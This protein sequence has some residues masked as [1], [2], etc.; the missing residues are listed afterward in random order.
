ME[1]IEIDL[2]G[3]SKKIN[4]KFIPLIKD[5][6]PLQIV[7]GG[8]NSS[9]SYSYAEKIIYHTIREKYFRCLATRKV[10]KDVKHSVYDQL[11][12]VL[13]RYKLENY[14]TYNNTESNLICKLNGNDIL[15]VGLDDVNKLKSFT[16][17]TF[18][19]AEEADQMTPND[20]EQLS[21]RLRGPE[22]C[23]FQGG[24]TLN[25]ISA[26]HWI[27][28][29]Y[30]NNE[31]VNWLTHRSTY[32]D[33]KFLPKKIIERME[34]ITDPYYKRVYVDGEWGI[35][36]NVVFTNY[37]IEDFDYTE[38]D[39]YNVSNGIDFGFAHASAFERCGFIDDEIYFF[40]EVWGKGWTNSDFIK[41]IVEAFGIECTGWPITAESA[42]PD[43]VEEFRRYGFT[44]F[45][46]AKKGPGSLKYGIDYL[47]SKKIHIHSSKCM[48]LAKEIQ[49]F[50]RRE[51]KDGNTID[52]FVEIN[53]DC[54]AAAR[55]AT[56]YIW[57]NIENI[58]MPTEY[59]LEDL[60]L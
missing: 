37:V 18:F 45:Q 16:N 1:Q 59:S 13:N 35:Y 3:F 22:Y 9:K 53:D 4:P 25:P 38:K 48:N 15:G 8:A 32:K 56:E 29:K 42:E 10:K 20:I 60:G 24:L 31:N 40:D 12:E 55:Y 58:Y 47:C 51:D 54:I 36:S 17:P 6:H 57:S 28:I 50:K 41:N 21:L 26:Q 5:R 30:F 27:K 52:A 34:N 2:K 44:N 19:W 49:M 11:R 23:F 33:N 43:R 46:E 39:L 7:V 14:F